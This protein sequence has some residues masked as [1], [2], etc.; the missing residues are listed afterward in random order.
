MAA[1]VVETHGLRRQFGNKVAVEDLSLTVARGEIFGF[2]GPNGAGKTTSLK[3]LL[4]LVP[5]SAGSAT[6]LGAPLGDRKTRAKLG[7][8]PEHFRFHDWLTGR[9]L[10]E[11]HGALYGVPG[12]RLRPRIDALLERVDLADAAHRR[13][14]EYSKGMLQ[15]I[16]LAQALLNEPELV[17]LDEPTA[18]LDPDRSEGFVKLIRELHDRLSFTVVM[19]THDLDTLVSVS[20]RVAVL[21]DQKVVV[22]GGLQ[23]V[24]AYDHPFIRHF[25]LGERGL[26]ALSAAPALQT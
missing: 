23:E 19:A 6:V 1:S 25:F 14:R 21:A 12:S 7:F 11:F 20:D 15:R 16:G 13:V 4:G 22:C 5:P 8:L 9:E 2:L 18:G 10:L 17:F 26:R 24:V 3:I